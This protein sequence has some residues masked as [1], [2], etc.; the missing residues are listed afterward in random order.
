MDRNEI[1]CQ[2]MQVSRGD[3]IDAIKEKECVT[4]Q[5]I[6]DETEAGTACGSCIEDIEKILKEING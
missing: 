2:C 3:I 5:D 1:I 4:V 6:G